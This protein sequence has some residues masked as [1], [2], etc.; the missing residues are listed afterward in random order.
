MAR[1]GHERTILAMALASKSKDLFE[2]AL[3][4][5]EEDL[6]RNEVC[7]QELPLSNA[8]PLLHATAIMGLDFLLGWAMLRLA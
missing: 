1:D 2:A 4:A 6:T 5:L 8:E 3:A 7:P